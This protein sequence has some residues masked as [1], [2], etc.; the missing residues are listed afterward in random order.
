MT[1]TELRTLCTSILGGYT[2]DTDLFG[3]LLQMAK[4]RR[5]MSR[6]WMKL[7]AIDVSQS[8]TASD[9]YTSTKALPARFLKIYRPSMRDLD[10]TGVALITSGGDITYLEPIDIGQRYQFKDQD[11]FYYIDHANNTIGRTGVVAG[12]LQL[13]Y[14]QGSVDIDDTTEWAFPEYAHP[15]LAFD[16]AIQQKGGIDWD[17][18]SSFSV[19]YNQTTVR[20]LETSLA[21]WDANLQQ[22]AL[23][24]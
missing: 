23:G 22:A 14:I 9:D 20:E 8:F 4:N 13:N 15:L 10:N 7:R 5:E 1:L 12:T 2:I 19:P 11:G 3:T 21:M 16:V 6:D 18:V 17:V 24:L